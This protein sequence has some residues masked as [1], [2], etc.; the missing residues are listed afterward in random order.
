MKEYL[1][2]LNLF[3]LTQSI[4][5]RD[6]ETNQFQFLTY[7]QF[8]ELADTLSDLCK[9]N[10]KNKIY[11]GNTGRPAFEGFAELI[12]ENFINNYSN[13]EVEIVEI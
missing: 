2:S 1:C 7:C 13:I 4:F 5:V 10:S 8:D 11:L 3:S 6:E 9:T 12:K